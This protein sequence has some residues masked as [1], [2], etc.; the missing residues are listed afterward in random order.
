[1]F[2][3]F[4]DNPTIEKTNEVYDITTNKWS[5]I[6]AYPIGKEITHQGVALVDDNI[7]LIGGRAVDA[8]GPV[9]SQVLIYN[10]PTNTWSNGPE[11]INPATGKAFPIGA[12]G[13][14]VLGRTIHVFG[15][16][17]PT[18]CEDQATLHLTIDVDKYM[19]NR[20]GV[21]WE[22]KLAPMPIP[23]NHISYVTLGGKVYAF[24]G[25]FKHDCGAVD[26]IYCHVYDSA[27]DKWTRLTDLPKPRSHAEAATFAIDGKMYL[28]GGQSYNNLPQNTTYQFTPQANNG[29]GAWANLTAYKLPG[30]FLGLSARL[31]N[32]KYIIANG[33]LD[34]YGNERR[35]TYTANV[36]RTGARTLGFTKACIPQRLNSGDTAIIS[37]LLYCIEDA[38]PYLLTSDAG[39][40]TITHNGGGVATLNGQDVKV[41][42]NTANLTAGSYTGNVTATAISTGSK[43]TFCVDLS[44]SANEGYT[45]TTL[46]IGGGT[47]AKMPDKSS[48]NPGDTVVVNAIPLPGWDFKGWAGDTTATDTTLNMVMAKNLSL[49]ATFTQANAPT[50][51][52]SNIITTTGKVYELSELNKGL[53]YYTDRLYKIT[54]VPSFLVNSSIIKTANDDKLNKTTSAVSFD[55]SQRATVYIAYDPRATKLP[56]WLS[57]WK[58]LTDRLGVDD[59]KLTSFSLYSKDFDAGKVTLGGNLASPAVKALCQYI[60]IARIAT[61]NITAK[62]ALMSASKQTIAFLAK[63]E[64][65]VNTDELK[66]NIIARAYIYPNPAYDNFRV[67]FPVAYK[68]VARME[69]IDINGKSRTVHKTH[70][71]QAQ[72]V[73]D[74]N[75]TPLALKSGLYSLLMVSTDGKTDV[76]RLIIN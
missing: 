38:T 76:F 65:H 20:D 49:N 46:P 29:L 6:A 11:L 28:A 55:L 22:N 56:L 24:G 67:V 45:L 37:N 61:G 50:A 58:K 26:Q 60:V 16:F 72:T 40:L 47:I 23:R 34:N 4:G 25:Q 73:V 32:K 44:I 14:A 68:G 2:G 35:E 21:T 71:K 57:G 69:V 42:V 30:A 74:V 13:Y 59:P 15:G 43:A 52:V 53:V 12:G 1:M 27:T 63:T 31:S 19:A 64:Q 3:G 54:S 8:Y 7:W 70:I 75:I 41:T 17:G 48:Y 66:N 33:A 18:I 39:W 10:I 9:S 36:T 62:I 51:L 5:L